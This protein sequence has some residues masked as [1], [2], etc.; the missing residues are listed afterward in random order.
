[1]K[2]H[3]LTLGCPKNV[4]D[5]EA[6]TRLLV[7]D[8]HVPVASARQADVVIVN[9]CGFID[10]AKEESLQALAK[11]GRAKRRGQVLIAAG[12]LAERFAAD[13][14]RQAP[15]V[16]AVLG[17]R[18]WDQ[19]P[20]LVARLGFGAAEPPDRRAALPAHTG[21]RPSAY[22]K[23]ADGCDSS[24]A[25]CVIPQIKGPYQSKPVDQV[26][27]EARDLADQ[28]V[29][30]IVLVAQ[31]TTLYGSDLGVRDGLAAL[32]EELLAAAP[33]VPW[34]RI[35]YAYPQHITPRLIRTMA[36]NPRVCRYLDLPLQ[37]AHPD[38]LQR[39]GRPSNVDQARELIGRLRQ[40]M[41]GIALRS[42]F[43]VGY[44]GETEAEFAALLAFLQEMRLDRAGFFTYSP[45]E[46]TV[47]AGLPAPVPARVKRARFGRAMAV[48]QGVSLAINQALVG[49]TLDVLM[50]GAPAD[51]TGPRLFAGRS[52]RDAPEVDGMVLVQ[53]DRRRPAR[54][55]TWWGGSFRCALPAP[56]SMTCGGSWHDRIGRHLPGTH[57]PRP[58]CG[59][60]VDGRGLGGDRFPGHPGGTLAGRAGWPG[61]VLPHLGHRLAGPRARG[62]ARRQAAR[63]PAGPRRHPVGWPVRHAHAPAP[64]PH[65]H[66][67]RAAA[68]HRGRRAHRE[69]PGP[70]GR[71]AGA[72]YQALPGAG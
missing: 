22:L 56:R 12:C 69:G 3:L 51:K 59:H 64:Q 14:Q 30:E 7:R 36:E 48:Q 52:Y 20:A 71:H 65:R 40:A 18:H 70:A 57:R 47:A 15:H 67:R 25:F 6:M 16:D 62:G 5:S 10:I 17:T 60:G 49:K 38:T 8:G 23:I 11:A 4:V 68:G 13:L 33:G 31:D 21:P 9:T 29:Q 41:P 2:F 42:S 50:E 35:M 28:G 61:G 54:R 55:R 58:Q 1:M 44:P 46:G 45:E 66:H 27:A 19:I 39:M 37:H 63:S 72:G 53:G 43:I 32:L 24:C 26:V 34:W